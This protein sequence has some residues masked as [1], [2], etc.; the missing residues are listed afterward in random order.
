MGQFEENR[1]SRIKRF[2]RDRVT[3]SRTELLDE[4]DKFM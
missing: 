3:A 1:D 2:A 4:D